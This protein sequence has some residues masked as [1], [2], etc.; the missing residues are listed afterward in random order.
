MFGFEACFC[1]YTATLR[2]FLRRLVVV[3]LI[4]F[5]ALWITSA[6]VSETNTVDVPPLQFGQNSQQNFDGKVI[7]VGAGASGLFCG[8]TLKYLGVE[9]FEILEANPTHF[10]GRVR[11]N[12]AFI[13]LPIDLG[14]EWI[15]VNPSIL[16]DL[17]LFEE[18]SPMPETIVYN[19]SSVDAFVR[20]N[21]RSRNWLRFF[22]SEYKFRSTTWYGYLN[23][24]VYPYVAAN[25]KLG[26][27]VRTID[28]ND[29][30]TIKVTTSDGTVLEADYVV[31]A[32]PASIL[33]DGD[34][35]FIPPLPSWKL[36]ALS[37]VRT[38]P[39]MK[40]WME[41]DEKFY[42]DIVLPG[43]ISEFISEDSIIYFDGAFRKPTDRKVLA[44]LLVGRSVERV[45]MTDDEAVSAALRD[46]DEIFDGAASSH[47]KNRSMVQNWSKEPFIKGTYATNWD[48]YYYDIPALAKHVSKRLYFSGDSFTFQTSTVHG[49]AISGRE[50]A[51]SILIDHGVRNSIE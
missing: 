10:G 47:F 9:T 22:Y 49:A 6:V 8:Y 46:L 42:A 34:I 38:A 13:D 33:H 12:D 16:K 28:Y 51:Q 31:L 39:G 19:P 45:E 40:L 11:E 26:S 29:P 15:H 7:V 20:G 4:V 23:Q 21:L 44:Q 36:N 43:T 41:F 30:E 32:V 5:I 50:A 27:V 35:Q 48:D 2:S 3:T 17:L 14:A 18:T 25:L 1:K 37:K 24:F